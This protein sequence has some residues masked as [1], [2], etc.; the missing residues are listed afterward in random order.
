MFS[1]TFKAKTG[2]G[3]IYINNW[4]MELSEKDEI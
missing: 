3:E 1:E 4:H 2:L